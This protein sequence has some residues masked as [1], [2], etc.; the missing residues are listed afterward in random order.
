MSLLSGMSFSGTGRC[1]VTVRQAPPDRPGRSRTSN[2]R[3]REARRPFAAVDHR[4]A[5][6]ESGGSIL[7]PPGRP[8]ALGAVIPLG[9]GASESVLA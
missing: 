1:S 3:R 5:V 7:W 9:S 8:A 4:G 2:L 6:A